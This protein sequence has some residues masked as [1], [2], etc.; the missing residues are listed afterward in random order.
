[1]AKELP[2]CGNCWHFVPVGEKSGQCR[3]YP[4]QVTALFMPADYGGKELSS[5]WPKVVLGDLCGE[6]VSRDEKPC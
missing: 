3:R 5:H 4:P 1:M 6:Y 2:M